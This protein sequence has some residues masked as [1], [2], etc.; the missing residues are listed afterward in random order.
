MEKINMRRTLAT[1]LLASTLALAACGPI[2]RGV[3]SVNQPV[4]S[5]ADYVLDVNAAGLTS[6]SSPEA[7]RLDVSR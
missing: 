6:A 4:V 7:K 1:G 5:R 3:E 2:N